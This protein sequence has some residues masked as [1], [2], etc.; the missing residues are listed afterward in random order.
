MTAS[1]INPSRQVHVPGTAWLLLAMLLCPAFGSAQSQPALDNSKLV[2]TQ[3]WILL[4][5]DEFK[6]RFES[7]APSNPTAPAAKVRSLLA[8]AERDGQIKILDQPVV[9]A[10]DQSVARYSKLI[11]VPATLARTEKPTGDRSLLVSLSVGPQI[12][13]PDL[14]LTLNIEMKALVPQL[15][16]GETATINAVRSSTSKVLFGPGDAFLLSLASTDKDAIGAPTAA[17]GQD[18]LML[19]APKIAGP[20]ARR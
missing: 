13:L 6:R 18:L 14:V 16:I 10:A 12:Q 9:A 1:H 4:A 3:L 15:K 17:Q 7:I 11:E 8:E 20:E 2:D 19:V 5:G